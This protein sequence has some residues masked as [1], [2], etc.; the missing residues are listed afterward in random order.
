GETTTVTFT[1]NKP[2]NGFDARDIG[3]TNGT[4]SLPTAN[5]E[6]TVWT[7]TLTPTANVNAPTN[8]IHADLTGVTDDA[9]NA[10][11]WEVSSTNYSVD[12]RPAAGT[13]APVDSSELDVNITIADSVLTAGETTTVTFTFNKPVNGFDARDIGCT[14]GTLSLPTANAERTVWT[15]TLTPTANVNAGANVIR[16]D[17]TGVTDDAGNAGE[18][19]VSS[20]NYSVDTRPAADT[21]APVLSRGPTAEITMTDTTLGIGEVATVTIRFSEKVLGLTL[22]DIAVSSSSPTRGTLSDLASDDGGQT[23]TVKLTPTDYSES[24]GRKAEGNT[25]V[26][27]QNSVTDL[28]GNQGPGHDVYSSAYTV[29][30]AAPGLAWSGHI[31][32][33][34][35]ETNNTLSAG[36]TATV[37]LTFTEAVRNL[38]A[39]HILSFTYNADGSVNW[40]GAAGGTLSNLVSTDGGTTWTA[41]LTAPTASTTLANVRLGVYMGSVTDESGNAGTEHVY[42]SPISYNIDTASRGPTAKITMTDTTLGIGEVATVTIRFSQKVLG[43]T[44]DDIAVSSSS[45]TRGTLSDLASNDG[46]QTWTVKLTPTGYS[47]S[48]GSKVGG[49]TIVLRQN[50]VTDLAGNQGPEH[51]VYS[52]AYTVDHAAPDL[53][54]SGHITYA[55]G[56]TDNTLNAGETATITLVF[57]EAVR[58]LNVGHIL[59]FTVNADGSANWLG[60]A[61]GTLSNLVSTDGGTTWI[62]TLTAPTASTTLTNVRLGVHIAPVTDESGNAGIDGWIYPSPIS[63]N[64]DTTTVYGTY[65]ADTEAP[66]PVEIPGFIATDGTDPAETEDPELSRGPTAKIT[67]T[68]TMLGIGEVA[69]VT[70]RF[71]KKILG[72]TFTLDDIAVSSSSPTRGTLSDL[73]SNDGGQTWTV[74]LTPTGYSDSNGRKV[75]GNTI[76]LRQNSVTDLAGNQGPEHDVYS[77]AYTVDHAAPGLAWSGHI[78]YAQGETDN[79]LNAGET[80]T[81][82]L[83]FTEAVRNLNADHILPFTYNADGSASWLGATGGTLSNLVSTDGGTT[84][85]ATL[86]APT[87]STTLT[88][89]RLG[90][91]MGSVTDEAGNAGTDWQVYP[92]PISY[93]IDTTTV[94]GTHFADTEAPELSSATVNGNQLVLRYADENNLDGAALVGNA[95]F[96]VSSTTGTAITVTGAVANGVAKTVTLTLSRAVTDAETVN[97]SYSKPATG[98]VVQDAKGNDAENFIERAVTNNT[99]TTVTI[100]GEAGRVVAAASTQADT[101]PPELGSATV[102]GNQLVL[103]YTEEN[104]LDG[105]ALAGNAGF[106]VSSTRG[107]AITVTGAV[108]DAAANTV[109]LTLSRAVTKEETVSLSYTKPATGAVVQ[110]AAGNDAADFSGRAVTNDTPATVITAIEPASKVAAA[111]TEADTTADPIDLTITIADNALTTGETTTV[112]FTFNQPVNGFD[113]SDI[114]CGSGTLSTPTANATRTVWT[115]TFTPTANTNAPTNVINVD[116]AR[117]TNDAGNVG[118]GDAASAN[119]TVDTRPAADTTP[120][121]FHSATVNGNQL[122]ISYTEANTL[123]EAALTGNAGFTVSSTT[124]TAI[125]VSSAVVHATN[126]TVT[127]TLSRAVASAET[128]TVSYAKPAAGA[129]VQDA[130]G[131][132]AVSFSDQPVTNNTRITATITLADRGLTANET[133]TVTFTFNEPVTGFGLEDVIHDDQAGT[134]SAPTASADGRTWTATLTPRADTYDLSGNTISV[135]LDGVTNAAGRAG[136]GTTSAVDYAVDTQLPR[137]TIELA[138][139]AL[140]VGETTTVTFTFNREIGG[141]FNAANVDLSNAN[142]TLSNLA[143]NSGRIW[144]ATFTPT[145]NLADTSNTISVNLA[146]VRVSG[147]DTVGQGHAISANYTVDTRLPDTTPPE[148]SSAAVNGDQL[149]LTYT[150]ANSLDG[151]ELTGNAGFTVSSSTDTAITVSSAVVN[152][153]DKTIT[154][155]LSRAVTSSETVRVSYT[156]PE[157]GAVVQ[158]AAGNDAVNFSDQ[159]V[160]NNTPA[161]ADTTAPQLITSDDTTRPRV[162]GDQLVLSFDDVSDLDAGLTQSIHGAFTVLVNG[163]ANAVTIVTIDGQAKTVTLTLS[164]AVTSGQTV[165]V[166]YADPTTGND[167][168]AIQDTAGNDAASFAATAVTNN[169]P[170]PADTTPPVIET[171]TVNG[172][173]LT[174]TYTDESNLDVVNTAAAS[175]YAV[176]SA[177]NEAI[178]VNIVTVSGKTVTLTLS[179]AVTSAETVTVS[180]TKPT[181]DNVIQDAAGNDA[182]SFSNQ[183]VTNNTPA[184]NTSDLTAS[185]T[186]FEEH[187]TTGTTTDVIIGFSKPVTGFTLADV[188]LTQANGTLSEL[189]LIPGGSGRTWTATF[190]PTAN[191]IDE[192]NTISVDLRGVTDAAGVAGI[193]RATSDNFTVSTVP[194]AVTITLADT[195]LTVG[196]TT[197]VTFAFNQGVLDFSI[198]D[199]VFDATTSTLGPLTITDNK[200]WTASLTPTANCNDATNTIRLD[201]ADVADLG[202]TFGT[203]IATSANYTVATQSADTTPPVISTAVVT[204]DQL[205]LTYTEAGT[206]DPAALTGNAGFTIHTASGT[207]APITVS[208][209]VVNGAAKTVTLTLSRTVAE[210]ETLSI[211]Y[212]KPESGNGVRDAAGNH[213]ANFN[214]V[215]PTHGTLAPADTTPPVF[216][217]AAVT[218]NQLVLSFSDTGNLDGDPVQKPASGAFTVLVNGVANAVTTVTVQPQAKTVTLTLSTA[219]T[220]GQSVTVA[221][222]DPTTGNDTNAIQDISGNDVASFAATAVTNNTPA[223]TADTTPPVFSS[224]AVTGDQ[225]VLSFS[226]TSNLEADPVHK[227]ANG[228][229]TVLVNGVANAVTNVTVQAQAKTVTLTLSTAVTHGQSVTV[230]YADPTTGNDTN[231]IQDAA[232]NDAASFAATAV[233]N[234]TPAGADTTPPVFSSATVNGDKLVISYTEQN[235]LADV[236]LSGTGGFTIYIHNSN[237]EAMYRYHIQ[238]AVVNGAANTVTL[239]LEQVPVYYGERISVSYAKPGSGNVVQDV[240]GNHAANFDVMTATNITPAPGDTTPPVFS[241]AAVTGNQLVISYTDANSLNAVTLAG[242]AGYAVN[243]AAGTVAITVSSAVVNAT[244]KTVTLTLSRAVARA[245]TVSVSYTKPATGAVVQDAA[246]NDAANF[247]DQAVTNNTLAELGVEITLADNALTTGETTTVTFTFNQP[248]N[249]F[250]TSDISCG[251]GTL[252]TPTANATR[253]VWTATFTPTADVNAPSNVIHVNLAGVTNAVGNAGEGRVNGPNYSVNT[254]GPVADTVAPVFSSATVNGNQLVLTYTE[255]NNLDGAALEQNAGFTVNTAA[256]TAA[257]RVCSAVVNATAKTVT[258]TLDRVVARAE[259]VSV[260]YTKP[261]SGAVVQ[262]AAGNDAANFSE[263]AVTNNTPAGADTTP[264]V[265]SSATVNGNKLVISYTEQNSLADV[266]ISGSGGFSVYREDYVNGAP[267]RVAGEFTVQSVVVNGAAKTVTL[268]LTERPV[269]HGARVTVSYSR[270]VSGLASGNVVQ[271]VAGNHAANFDIM[272]VTNITPAPGDTT[273]PVFSSAA[274]NGDQLVI[275]YTDANSLD[276]VALAGNAG[277]AV[278]TAAGTAAITVSSAVVNATAKTVTLTLSRI[279]ASTETVS[280]SYTKPATGAV[281]QDAARNDAANFSDQAVTNNTPAPADTTPPEFSSAAV[282]GDQLVLTYT[283]ANSLD[284]AELTGNAGFTVSSSTDTAITVSSAVVNG[285]DKTITLTLSRAVTSTETV[286]VSYTKPESGAVVQDAAGNDAVS[287]SDQ[288][289]TNNTPA[290]ADTTAP[291]LITSD[292]T[293]RPRVNGDQLVLSFDDVSDLDAGLTELIHGA[294]TVLVN[295]VANAVTIVTIDGQAKT[296]TLTLSTAVTHGQ[297]VTVAY[298]D[299]TTDNDANAIQDAAGNDATSFAATAVTNNT[300]APADTTPPEFSRATVNGDQLMISYTEANSLDGAELAGNA[301]FTVSSSSTDTAITVS[302][303]VVNGADKTITLTLSRAVTS[304]E[305]VT[306]SYTK[307]E[308]GAVVQDA[309]GNDAVSFSNQAVTNN[310]PA[311]ADTTAPQLITSDDTTRPRVNGDQLVLSFDDVSDLDAG[312]IESIHG[313]FTVLVNGVA[314]AIT[315]VTIDGQAKT[316]TLTLSTAVT[317]G[318]TVTVAYADPTTDN[319]ANAIQDAAGNDAASFAATAVVNNTPAPADTTAPVINTATVNGN[320]LVL[321]YTEANTL[322]AAALAG[323]AGFTVN[324]AAAGM[325][326]ITVG[327][328]VVNGV[329][330]TVTLTLSRAVAPDETLSVSY[331]QPESGAVVQDAAGNDAVDFS[332]RAVTNNTPPELITTGLYAPRVNGHDLYLRFYAASNLSQS[333]TAHRP[334]GSDFTVLVDGR[335]VAATVKQYGGE[336]RLT[337]QLSTAVLQGQTVT[338]SYRDSTPT[339]ESAIQDAAGNRL[340]SFP[341]TVVRTDLDARPPQLITSGDTT[342]PRVNGDQLTLSFR[343]NNNLDATNK[344][345]NEAFA[346]LVDGTARA[347]RDVA[348]NAEAKTVTLT[349][350]TAVTRGQSVTVAYA[351]PRPAYDDP[352]AIQD[353]YGQDAASFAATAVTNNTPADTTPPEFSSAVVTGNQLVLTYTEAGTLD[354]AALA[355]N[356]GFTVSSTTGTA[357]TVTGAVVNGAA[358]TITLTLSRAVTSAETVN[359]SYTQPESGAVVQDAAGNDAVNFSDQAVTNNTPAPSALGVEITL[360][361]NALTRGEATTVTFTFNQPVNGFDISD[362]VCTNGTLSAPVANAAGTVW[363]A[364]FTPTANVNAPVNVITVGLTGVTG[365]AGNA[366]AGRVSSTNYTVNTTGGPSTGDSTNGDTTP[367]EFRSATANGNQVVVTYTDESNLSDAALTGNAGFTVLSVG[368][369]AITVTG[370]LVNATAKTVTLTLSRA[371]TSQERLGMNYTKPEGVAGVADAA[372]NSAANFASAGVH[373]NTPAGSVETTPPRLLVATVVNGNQLELTYDDTDNL[374]DTALTGNAGF[375]LSGA[376]AITVIGAVVH[377][378]DKTITLTLSR[379]A[380]HRESLSLSYTKP[381][382]GAVVQD[383]AG[384]DAVDVINLFVTNDTP[385]DSTPPVIE[386][387]TVNGNQL[388]LT[389]TDA[390]NL[391]AVN[392]AA[393]SAYA[394]S[395]AGNAAISVSS[396]AVSGKTVTLTLSRAVTSAETVTVSYTKPTDGNN[397]VQDAAGNDAVSFSDRAVTNSTPPVADTTAPAFIT[398]GAKA[399]KVNA[400]T[401]VLSFEDTGNLDEDASHTPANGA[402][403]V[404]VNGVANAVTNVTVQAQAKTVTLTLSTAVTRGQTVTVAYADPTTG[405]DTNAIQDTAG[406]DVASFAATAVRND[407][408]A[409]D[410]TPPEFRSATANGNQVVV[411]YTDE[412]N[413]SDAALTGNA[414][415]TVLSVGGSAITVTGALVNATAKTVTLTL[416]RAVTSQER[417]AMNYTKPEGV[418]AGVADA[419]GNS[420]VNFRE[421]GV[422][423]NTPAGSVETTPP[424]LLVATVVNGNQLVLTYGDTDNLDDTALT[425][426][427]GFTLSGATAITV[428]GAVVQGAAKTI[429]LTLSRAAAHRESLSLSYTKPATGAVVQDVAGNDAVDVINL[430]VTNDTPVDTTPPVIETTT[431]TGNQ[432]T[433]TYTDASNLDVV[434]TAAASAY[435]VSSAG[436]AAI[437]V[438]SVAVSGKTVTLTL[439][440]AVTSAETVTVSYT[441]PTDG[442]NVVQDAAGNDAVSFSDRAVTNSTPPVADTTAPAFITEGAKAP[443]VNAS[444]LVLSFED[445]GNLDADAS[446]TPANGAFTVLVNGVANTVTNVSVQAQAKT[447]TLTLSTAVTRGQTVTVAYADPTTGNDANAIQDAA[448]N[449]A[450]SFAATAVRNDTP[451]ADTTPPEFRSATA[452]GNQVVVTYTDESNLSDAALTGNAGFTVLSVGGSAITVT[453]ALVNAT[454]K[455]VTLTLSRAVTSPERL[456]MNYTKP[457]GVAGVADAAGNSAVNFREQGVDNNTPAGSV[458]TTPPRLLVAT[459]VNGNQLELTYGDTDNLDDTALT[460][461]AGFTLSGATAITVIG[462]VVRGAA[463]TITLT[464]SRAA[465]HR[466]S[467]SLSYTKPATGAVVQ[468]VAGNDAVDVINLFVTN[469]TP[470]DSTPPVIETTTVN[471]NQLTLTYTDASNLD[472]VNTAAAS[473]F[474]VSSAGNAAISVSSVA[475]S[476]KTVTLTLSRAVTSAE[477]V[478]VSYT[479]PTD[480]NNV[481]QDAAGND[482]VS[483]SDQA[484]TN[485]TPSGTAD[486]TAPQLLTTG[487][488]RPT[489]GGPIALVIRFSDASNLDASH[490]PASGDFT[491]LAD[492]SRIIVTGVDV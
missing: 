95:G 329:A 288:A 361:D 393:A 360:A 348:V 162:N 276:V 77:F 137:V 468:D 284:G 370:A 323:S 405:N 376:T 492:G 359:V 374:D 102:N 319:D 116:L 465:A 58:N 425:G 477:T 259:T 121:V 39:G 33:A 325:A 339:D 271:D 229:F 427:A 89:V 300:P 98:S 106:A 53:A 416:S 289:V 488:H 153:A 110:D 166:A 165:T 214:G 26:L 108:V 133:T 287:F 491:V 81:V 92:S 363:T 375:T 147:S 69:T 338:V 486:T 145:D 10:G 142:G 390:S 56:E 426:N 155:T 479:K 4:L 377:G 471:G 185:I 254:T 328:A 307:P 368:G 32:Y 177:G 335:A 97:V 299:P 250:D 24:N 373:N 474:A 334:S 247:S 470:V 273:P 310:T 237:G 351:D 210:T 248:V 129:V 46:G 281:V 12:T 406:N 139:T 44:L 414:G 386:T 293:T 206:L 182:A 305:T 244:A 402:F 227:P 380:A 16:A 159:E 220:H 340:L 366:G 421:Q 388:T 446:H 346:V 379:A 84:W 68:D 202:R 292:D 122:V 207:A 52:F 82:T 394:V 48:N 125:T 41:T 355:G 367:P 350:A 458:E 30:H 218:G 315:I 417:L 413:L 304:T 35:G 135:R 318:Q 453:G 419:A 217:S 17:L 104:N 283:E 221:Y 103:R 57:T 326:A 483:F 256:G 112:T 65:P 168:N 285:A 173:Q 243:T 167:T 225:L 441:K 196:E 487:A 5:A 18:W 63:Y 320:Q 71:S 306:V 83:A 412:S 198:H 268:A 444:T 85:T 195:A 70:I 144:T 130:A 308:S 450:T 7:A 158:D 424:R 480:G 212:T 164:T 124:G 176:S 140:R 47:E 180:Y 384:N 249:G 263:R 301:G 87:A 383:V 28:A 443:K 143:N 151:A 415:F 358:K 38:N 343:D 156:K 422:D 336:K 411:T 270:L 236:A 240:A 149:V 29:D 192:S 80:A 353:I 241:S 132:D 101:T 27:R 199:I 170:A 188:D 357:I 345:A 369:S 321:T 134:L 467:L 475:V 234:N 469:D 434:N 107:T 6:R 73:L 175:A 410:T 448:G 8:V 222:A 387:T 25:I 429:T 257:I 232:G 205:V 435:A 485:N 62:A 364:A 277:Y 219:V 327:S 408:P 152:G 78:T 303:A 45:P 260:S 266:T 395:S 440:R 174:L 94:Y 3:C 309:A 163:V 171:T 372:G 209:A 354:E 349:L 312:L 347:V 100:T 191:V 197:T 179:R 407:T 226:D 333:L 316:V 201:L 324:T 59:S 313:A 239:T 457:E 183:A 428:T 75:G 1:F 423:N 459:V 67:M 178:S 37:T 120:P 265:F 392:T 238:S 146:G 15:A 51:D 297:T 460:G 478:T 114:S 389:Y 203:G 242:N 190:T 169:T 231:A 208:S 291:Q 298:A 228:A 233:T 194:L 267:V 113:T 476:G 76:V 314:N 356:A 86:T 473:A 19:E 216:S 462:A 20:T 445:T 362:I 352:S 484:V 418:V 274:V 332:S 136:Q 2:V 157:S 278:N 311:P 49:N 438:S 161:P 31:T 193:G 482:A 22:D 437:S 127:L 186:L 61:G 442:N 382:T 66:E 50:S 150:E 40:L 88:N 400:S 282:N 43:F 189:E 302:S 464:L 258:L 330:K 432:L 454:A 455:T 286:T 337:L 264:P 275:S 215:I 36:E 181:G 235:S 252:S 290:P 433:L 111:S 279:V 262:D 128:V 398:E 409:A 223:P 200:T 456:A 245:E 74:K 342:R 403:T 255:A 60:A 117:V 141:G 294:F 91:Y 463:K 317:H 461:N 187:L 9:G 204:G 391:D 331:T 34:P 447:V 397:V 184:S 430:F 118:E 99:P 154:L 365:A 96:T 21:A 172:N 211:V 11:E 54:W 269:Y 344:P 420:A 213:A 396:V 436:N 322:D 14:N 72:S 451:A 64:I 126:K 341:T 404:L 131:N 138:N 246:R 452:N 381:A 378:A 481:I 399:P 296:V 42:V 109:T 13:G 280:V 93:N 253:T 55:Q 90:V 251:S 466:E 489:L 295:G 401:L 449:D 224:A 272:A 119:Y 230:A 160:T 490:A 123:D 23:W 439:S 115:A 371:V 105:A 79:T 148:F 472:V 261:E 431:V 385:V